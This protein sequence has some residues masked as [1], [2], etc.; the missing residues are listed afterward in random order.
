MIE[1]RKKNQ[2]LSL[3]FGI[4][5]VCLSRGLVFR[6]PFLRS[7][8]YDPMQTEF[9]LT[10]MQIAAMMSVYN[11]VKTVLYIP[12]GIA[13]DKLGG[14][15]SVTLALAA[16]ALLSVWYSF[17][18][19]YYAYLA[20]QALFGI[21]INFEV[22]AVIK[23][24]RTIGGKDGQ[25]KIFGI[26]ELVRGAA[27]LG[28]NFLALGIYAM[29]QNSGHAMQP[30]LLTYAA[31]YAVIAVGIWVFCPNTDVDEEGNRIRVGLK[32]YIRVLK[33]PSVW[34]ITLLT[35]SC[36][37]VQT[38][39]DYTT[40]YLTNI[41]GMS[42]VTAG[43]IATVRSYGVS[44]FSGPIFGYIN[45]KFKSY[46]RTVIIIYIVEFLIGAAFILLPGDPAYCGIGIALVM[47]SA[48]GIYG[49]NATQFPLYEE[50]EIPTALTGTV[51]TIVC[52]IGYTPDMW[53]SLLIGGR[54]DNPPGVEAYKSVFM[55][56]LF[57]SAISL[58]LA[59]TINRVAH[60]RSKA[61]LEA[62]T[63]EEREK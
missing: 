35:V 29:F 14:R 47:L 5:F 2:N 38:I 41:M 42:A 24:L 16:M 13:V 10:H 52:M 21:A 40:P 37:S 62:A 6:V 53:L 39:N 26:G 63:N 44:L 17:G 3:L 36:Y 19:G 30:V 4:L 46:S 20:I 45:D 56:M 18:P 25:G 49:F 22:P 51:T 11:I 32:D 9:G 54:L 8:F 33:M 12:C 27:S 58:I 31:V 7:V 28:I 60:Q 57:F 55:L 34:M 61:R 1:E 23:I 15:K 59:V 43:V 50:C 48:I